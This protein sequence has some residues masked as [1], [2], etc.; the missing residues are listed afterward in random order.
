MLHSAKLSVLFA[1]LVGF[2]NLSAQNWT[3][4]YYMRQALNKSLGGAVLINNAYDFGFRNGTCVLG[5]YLQEG[6][7]NS[8]TVYLSAGTTYCF[9]GGGTKNAIDV[10]IKV[11]NQ[12]GTVVASDSKIDGLPIVEFTPQYSGDYDVELSLYSCES[13]GSFCCMTLLQEGGY[14]ISPARLDE[15]VERI[16]SNGESLNSR[17][18]V[19]FH[20]QTNEWSIYRTLLGDGNSLTVE[21]IDLG[22]ET[23]IVYTSGESALQDADLYLKN[24]GS[25]EESDTDSDATPVL[26]FNSYASN[27]YS[28]GI[29]HVESYS[30]RAIAFTCIMT[31]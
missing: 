22:T 25:I 11:I 12:S 30:G 15:A 27:S 17:V 2:T 9:V 20:D 28:L 8:Y 6:S 19:K 16:I 4:G 21:N 24:R 1:L 26:R 3:P 5:A 31:E 7:A 10:D 14:D 29:K 18:S 23:H 13:S